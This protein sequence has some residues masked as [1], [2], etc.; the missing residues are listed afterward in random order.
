VIPPLTSQA[1]TIAALILE[2]V[3]FTYDQTCLVELLAHKNREIRA[4]AD[5]RLRSMPGLDVDAALAVAATLP[6]SPSRPRSPPS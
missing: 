1:R 4:H 5:V 2:G 6:R 3:T